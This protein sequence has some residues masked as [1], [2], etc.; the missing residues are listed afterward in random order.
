MQHYNWQTV[1]HATLL[2]LYITH[3][4]KFTLL[5][6]PV[7]IPWPE[8]IQTISLSTET[9]A[10]ICA[11]VTERWAERS[12]HYIINTHIHM[13]Q[14][15]LSCIST[16]NMAFK[17]FQK[18][19]EGTEFHNSK[20]TFPLKSSVRFRAAVWPPFP[21]HPSGTWWLHMTDL[22]ALTAVSTWSEVMGRK[23]HL[24]GA[25]KIEG[26]PGPRRDAKLQNLIHI[27]NISKDLL[28]WPRL[29]ARREKVI[30]G[31]YMW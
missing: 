8:C 3:I 12:L 9:G 30:F 21:Q 13:T 22:P 23:M 1:L 10:Q 15:Y 27:L 5:G 14:K 2:H 25:P 26:L 20:Y 17:C 4:L 16:P 18:K 19:S 6:N 28:I 31:G 7:E 29:R 24:D 11:C